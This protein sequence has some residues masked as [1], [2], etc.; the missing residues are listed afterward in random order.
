MKALAVVDENWNIGKDGELLAHLPK[1]L[2]YFKKMTQGEFLIM[3]RK[4]L[5]SLPKGRA[6]P[7][8]TTIVLTKNKDYKNEEVIIVHSI[9]QLINLVKVLKQSIEDKY[10]I[11]CGG[12]EIYRQLLDEINEIAI[13]KIH[14]TFNS[15][16][17]KFPNLDTDEKWERNVIDS[18]E[19]GG[20]DLSLLFY[21]KVSKKEEE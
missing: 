5:E 18:F 1:D 14:H 12:G 10:F 11:V 17:T 2:K 7:N 9:K 21:N 13:T 4:T 20:Y 15:C 16:D 19:D 8:R 3:G 6:L